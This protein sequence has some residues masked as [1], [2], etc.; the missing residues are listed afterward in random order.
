M[1]H[2]LRDPRRDGAAVALL[3]FVALAIAGAT[4]LVAVP[5]LL[6]LARAATSPVVLAPF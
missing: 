2:S 4:L 3:G 6:T 5:E 1:R